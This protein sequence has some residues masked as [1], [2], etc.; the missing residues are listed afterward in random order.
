MKK[1]SCYTCAHTSVCRYKKE[2]LS[3]IDTAINSFILTITN[4]GV[5]KTLINTKT[6]F[7]AQTAETALNFLA[8][9]CEEH[10]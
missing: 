5:F 10:K 1:K 9:N 6:M 7:N 3:N 2:L 8:E 4:I